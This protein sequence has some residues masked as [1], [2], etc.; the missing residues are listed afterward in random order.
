MNSV[1][2]EIKVHGLVQGVGYRYYC[3][4]RGTALGLTG[5]VRNNH[6]RT[7]SLQVEGD[8][9]LVESLVD[10]LRVGPPA[11]SVSNVEVKDIPFSG[12]FETFKI[13]M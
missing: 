4:Q 13:N 2:V 12:A 9:S 1:A 6:D 11:S 8:R 10:D 5:W 3:F 7:V